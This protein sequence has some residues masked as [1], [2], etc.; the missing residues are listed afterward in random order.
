L[1]GQSQGRGSLVA[2]VCGVAQSQ[3]RLSDLAVAPCSEALV[4]ESPACHHFHISTSVHVI[5]SV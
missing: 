5:P 2:T 4:S 1:P 3:T